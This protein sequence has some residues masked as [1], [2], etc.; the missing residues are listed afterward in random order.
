MIDDTAIMDMLIVGDA[1][2]LLPRF[3]GAGSSPFHTYNFGRPFA[4]LQ[5]LCP[6]SIIDINY[7]S[8]YPD[9]GAE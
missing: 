2:P 9:G 4:F 6:K 5:L 8:F 7:T 3:S 1:T